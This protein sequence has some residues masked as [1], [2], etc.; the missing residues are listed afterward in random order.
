MNQFKLTYDTALPYFH[1]SQLNNKIIFK[2]FKDSAC[3]SP[4]HFPLAV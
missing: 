2:K 3:E 4:S 1:V